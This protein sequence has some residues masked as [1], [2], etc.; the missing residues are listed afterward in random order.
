MNRIY[1]SVAGKHWAD[2]YQPEREYSEN[3]ATFSNRLPRKAVEHTLIHIKPFLRKTSIDDMAGSRD[4][5]TFERYH[6]AGI[7][8]V[9]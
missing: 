4:V 1:L 6:L 9:L 7:G 3:Q 5:V 2:E 8:L